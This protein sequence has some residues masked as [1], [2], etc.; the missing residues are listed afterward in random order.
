MMESQIKEAET[1]EERALYLE[2][3]SQLC[4]HLLGSTAKVNQWAG[5]LPMFS[6]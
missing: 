6:L 2:L 5:G 4:G 1:I 3:F